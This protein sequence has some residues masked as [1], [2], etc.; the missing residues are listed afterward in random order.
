VPEACN[1]T[2]KQAQIITSA[3]PFDPTIGSVLRARKHMRNSEK[4]YAGEYKCTTGAT[5]FRET[6][7]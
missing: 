2:Y 7:L 1:I 6:L 5:A 4:L 3:L